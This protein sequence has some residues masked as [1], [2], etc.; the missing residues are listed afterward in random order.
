MKNKKIR[1]MI[2]SLLISLSFAG[3][4]AAQDNKEISATTQ[5]TIS[6]TAPAKTSTTGNS[7]AQ[8]TTE[9]S[10]ANILS[11]AEG[12]VLDTTEFFSDR[13]LEQKADL[14]AAKKVQLESNKDVTLNQ[15]GVYVLSGKVENVTVTV[16]AAEDAKVQIVLDGVSITNEDSPAI[17]VKSADKV[18][19]TSTDSKNNMEVSGSFA[20]DGDTNLD[21]VIFSK[22]DLTLNGVGTLEI[23]SNEGNGIASKDDLK[24][25]GGVYTI[26][27]SADGMEANDSIRIYD[28]DITIES[29][30]D[31][32]HSENDEDKALGYIYIRNGK[33]NIT[34]SDDAI[35]ANSIVQ[36]DG[37]A[38]NIK[39]CAEGIE[40]TY[41]QI[42]GGEIDI[43]AKDDGINAAPKSNYDV[44]IELNGGTIHISMGSGD[45]DAVDSNGDITVNGGTIDIEANSAFD[46]DGTAKLN[47]GD[48]TVNGEKITQ[49]TQSQMGRGKRH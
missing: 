41:V 3:C 48:V 43:Y 1:M 21:A 22:A 27:S 40:G 46:S 11:T 12:S 5:T 30:K 33:L 4:T 25:T 16:E 35:H 38:I 34:A 10:S 14:T 9:N 23:I 44:L 2:L 6:G 37:G 20:A 18:F 45:T 13:D 29:D 31:A 17:Y 47:G 7:G 32:L 19:V 39:T 42:N 36:I 15:E 26:R 49:I 24:V 28:G 8:S